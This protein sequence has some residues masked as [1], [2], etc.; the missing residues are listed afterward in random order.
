MNK[1]SASE[2]ENA[3]GILSGSGWSE[4]SSSW[5][6][7]GHNHHAGSSES[8]SE[9][10]SDQAVRAHGE[11][12]SGNENECVSA[13]GRSRVQG[14]HLFGTVVHDTYRACV[15]HPQLSYE[16][17]ALGGSASASETE[18]KSEVG[19]VRF[20][21]EDGVENENASEPEAQTARL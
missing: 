13:Y 10:P 3:T 9:V 14:G 2:S 11:W 19:G 20:E 7:R 16:T 21:E 5:T 17:Q 12:G 15:G 4:Q 6:S 1:K 18:R 8:V